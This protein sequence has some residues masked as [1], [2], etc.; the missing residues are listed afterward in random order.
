[1]SGYVVNGDNMSPGTYNEC[2]TETISTN[3]LKKW[4]KVFN[5]C[6]IVLFV[7]LIIF[8]IISAYNSSC[9]LE[10]VE[11]EYYLERYVRRFDLAYF[12]GYLL[13]YG[14]AMFLY[15]LLYKLTYS[16]LNCVAQITRNTAI[17]AKLAAFNTKNQM[18]KDANK[19][20]QN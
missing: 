5:I 20:Q 14:I 6:C 4:I 10:E 11:S 2:F 17:S 12:I 1:M 18:I 19:E 8:G 9:V 3:T 15:F 7:I 13:G 16:V